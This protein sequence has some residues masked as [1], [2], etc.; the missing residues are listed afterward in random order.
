MV[1]DIPKIMSTLLYR[2]LL[3]SGFIK[4]RSTLSIFFEQ[5]MMLQELDRIGLY[6]HHKQTVQSFYTTLQTTL[7][8]AEDFEEYM[9]FI[10][11]GVDSEID[12]LRNIAFHSDKLLLEY[13]QLLT[14]ITGV[15]NV[16]VKFV[17]NQ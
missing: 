15:S 13:Q 8:D 7:K 17:M 12:N 14:D 5:E 16:K 4:L 9:N 6:P 1:A 2:K 10:R 11:D 3:P